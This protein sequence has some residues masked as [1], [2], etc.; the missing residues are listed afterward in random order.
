MSAGKVGVGRLAQA[1]CVSLPLQTNPSPPVAVSHQVSFCFLECP[2]LLLLLSL[3]LLPLGLPVL[4][5]PPRL[6]CDSRVLERYILEAREAEN[7]TVSP[8][9]PPRTFHRI[10]SQGLGLSSKIQEPGN[11]FRAGGGKPEPPVN[12]IKLVTPNAHL[13]VR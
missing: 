13:G 12:M 7:V 5:T 6:I 2:A 4:G 11:W 10:H 8:P 1:G 9:P 3:L